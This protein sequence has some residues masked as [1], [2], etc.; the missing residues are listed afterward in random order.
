MLVP[1]TECTKVYIQREVACFIVKS[2][3]HAR[4]YCKGIFM[5]RRLI[6]LKNQYAALQRLRQ[7]VRLLEENAA[8]ASRAGQARLPGERQYAELSRQCDPMEV[9]TSRLH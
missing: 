4:C 3:W 5:S 8:Q 1:V 7:K 6:N 9:P 2:D